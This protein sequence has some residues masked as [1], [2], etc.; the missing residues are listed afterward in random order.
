[1]DERQSD[2]ARAEALR[3]EQAYVSMLYDH[4]DIARERA[5]RGMR[6]VLARGAAGTRQAVVEREVTAAEH[7]RRLAQLSAVE[8]GLCFGRIDDAEGQP[9]YIGRIGLRDDDHTTVLVDWRAPAARPFYVA[10]PGDPGTLVRRRHLHTR[11][12][13]VVG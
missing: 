2:S 10:T 13:T 12:R 8:R 5:E 6:E 4:L 3:I 11:D 7:A 1:M 9:L